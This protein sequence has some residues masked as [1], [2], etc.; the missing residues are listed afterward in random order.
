MP[1]RRSLPQ[2]QPIASPSP[3][4]PSPPQGSCDPGGSGQRSAPRFPRM[5]GAAARR[6]N[7]RPRP[8]EPPR[9]VRPVTAGRAADAAPAQTPSSRSGSTPTDMALGNRDGGQRQ[10]SR[11]RQALTTS[12]S[13]GRSRHT[14]RPNHH[15][16]KRSPLSGVGEHFGRGDHFANLHP[17]CS[18]LQGRTNRRLLTA[19]TCAHSPTRR[20][21]ALPTAGQNHGALRGK[22]DATPTL[23]CGFVEPQVRGGAV[24]RGPT[25]LDAVQG[26]SGHPAAPNLLPQTGL[27][28]AAGRS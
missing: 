9:P 13:T 1:P 6:R 2:L 23:T 20:H 27:A 25:P 11:E 26:R 12:T 16:P 14:A 4:R 18:Q 7:R 8:G 19:L 17:I 28:S 3:R 5:R 21:R 22:Q 15:R 10:S 24:E